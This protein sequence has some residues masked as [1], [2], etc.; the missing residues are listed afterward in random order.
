MRI[1]IRHIIFFC[2]LC[3]VPIRNYAQIN[4]SF[5]TYSYADGLIDNY[6]ED[7][8]EDSRGFIWIATRAGLDRFDGHSFH[9]IVL[10]KT[11]SQTANEVG[12]HFVTAL[13]EDSNKVVWIGTFAG[14]FSYNLV[15]DTYKVYEHDPNNVYS[16]SYNLI[17]EIIVDSKN[18]VWIAT[19]NGLNRYSREHDYFER[20][21]HNPQ[22]S[23][24]LSHNYIETICTDSDNNIW[25]GTLNGTLELLNYSKKTLTSCT[26]FENQKQLSH[27][28]DIFE[29]S[30][31]NIWVVTLQGG[32]FC[33]E[34]GSEKF[35][36]Y[37]TKEYNQNKSFFSALSSICEDVFGNMWISSHMGGI[38]VYDKKLEYMRFF[39]EESPGNQNIAT[40]SI[41]TIYRD[42]HD[43]MWLA[44][45][46][47]GVSVLSPLAG[48]VSYFEK[49]PYPN[50]LQGN[51]VSSFFE[52]A[53]KN[54]WIGSDGGGLS[55]Y[56][57]KTQS[58]DNFN[59]QHGL[60]SQAVLDIA[61]FDE[62]NIAVATWNGGLNV[63]NVKQKRF[64]P[65]EFSVHGTRVSSQN[66]YGLHFDSTTH[67]IWCSTFGYG[68][69]IFDV[70]SKQFL[71]TTQLRLTYPA[72]DK[73][74]FCSK[75]LFDSFSNVWIVDGIHLGRFDGDSTYFYN[76][77]DSLNRCKNGYFT[78]DILESSTN[79]IYVAKYDGV[80]VY[81][82]KTDCLE[83]LDFAHVDLTNAKA[84][85]EDAHGTI[86][87]ST[88]KSLFAFSPND[89][90]IKDVSRI[91]GMPQLQ[92]NTKAA[93]RS[94]TGHLFFGGLNGFVVL[95]EDSSYN[96]N[97]H[98]S[99]YFTKLFV[100]NVQ[101]I[102]QQQNS[103]LTK[104]FSLETELTLRHNQSSFSIEFAV[105]NFV[106]N[107]KTN[108]KYKLEGFD[109]DWVFGE[110]SRKVTY[111]NIPHGKYIF[112]VITTTSDNEWSEQESFIKI[113]VLPPWWKTLWFKIVYIILLV[114]LIAT[115]IIVRDRNIRKKNKQL[116]RLVNE[117]TSQLKLVNDTLQEQ[118]DTIQNHYESLREQQ[119]VI[120]I[121]NEQ[122][123][124]VLN[125]KNKLITVIAHDFKNPLST[126]L[127][128]VKLLQEKIKK[129]KYDDLLPNITSLKKS[130]EAIYSQMVEVLEWSLSK[131]DAVQYH[132]EE[133]NMEELTATVLSLVSES[134]RQ[135]NIHFTLENT[136][137]SYAFVDSRMMSAILRNLIINSIKFTPRNGSIVLK[138]FDVKDGIEIQLHD[139]GIGMDEELIQKLLSENIV[140]SG[141][142]Q[143]GFGLQICK[144]FIAR[145]KGTLAIESE[146]GKGSSFFV[147]VPKGKPLQQLTEK[148]E[149]IKKDTISDFVPE[150]TQRCMLIV[151]DN[152]EITDYLQ[153]VFADSFMVF[154]AHNGKDG[155]EKALQIIPEI[156]ISD[157]RM[158]EMDG[159]D[160]CKQLKTNNLTRHIPVILV[161][162]K[163]LPEEQIEGFEHGADDYITKP[164][165]IEVLKQK[166]FALM[167]HREQLLLHL[168][169]KLETEDDFVLPDSF[170]DKIIKDI[171]E[172]VYRNINNFDFKVD[173]LAKEVGLSRSQLYRKTSSVIGQS[174]NEYIKTIRLQRALEMLKTKR[175]RI[176]E[177]AYEVGFADPGYFSACFFERYGIKPSDYIRK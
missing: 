118:N 27:I 54:I 164:F 2:L 140:L 122:L 109:T 1:V 132:P 156:I 31:K 165:N 95:H 124:E 135:K 125:T 65:L 81:N 28:Q 138:M 94:S 82:R 145:N 85:L 169:E 11:G 57:P 152:V 143:S 153:E 23:T 114:L 166:V 170:D 32:V 87:I 19:R 45:H 53:Q 93:F 44:S 49:S 151:D 15:N 158:P 18:T 161:S 30:Q 26:P 67:Q 159:K 110:N 63:F 39:S 100:N 115:L 76:V 176:A 136:V 75:L 172:C 37:F 120:E 99:V 139:S 128:F 3:V 12:R 142:F 133:V 103:V 20:I 14:L 148:K 7:I 91:W 134:L 117:K 104:D 105:L 174:P 157:I 107:Q 123:Q 29:D 175:Y 55:R 80:C 42:S 71:D 102:P 130:T 56:N 51:I 98:P 111:T 92:Y 96:Y 50:S 59:F 177:I 77:L 40:N 106:D 25:I 46:G 72:W 60:S 4:Y 116:E 137:E 101:Q 21:M 74:M 70:K 43:N 90:T 5:K 24:S 131:D 47:G 171:T 162:A 108:V 8:F 113:T 33:K 119:L 160:M 149:I 167:K 121:K 79:Q 73:S 147:T 173:M 141:H 9:H 155:L 48:Q 112:K 127:G 6:V 168:K 10:P 16:L 83:Y 64:T 150:D 78:S 52:D 22:D 68:V 38:A 61:P 163:T 35:I 129:N 144:M 86:W 69:Q 84:L 58:F 41:K 154:V 89:T 62:E 13:A 146:E 88:A 34:Y 17:D 126:L 97:I 66:I 36:P